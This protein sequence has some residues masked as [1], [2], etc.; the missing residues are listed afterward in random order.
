MGEAII[1]GN[2]SGYLATVDSSNRLL[3]QTGEINISGTLPTTSSET[4]KT[5]IAY[6][7]AVQEYIGKALPGASKTGSVWQIQKLTYDGYNI[8]DIEF[9]GST[10][11]FNQIWTQRGSVVYG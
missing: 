2:G 9:A 5:A 1:D 11:Q 8:T 3:V 7:G 6:S 10:N 4:Y